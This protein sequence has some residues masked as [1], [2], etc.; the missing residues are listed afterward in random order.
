MRSWIVLTLMVALIFTA[1]CSPRQNGSEN[2]SAAFTGDRD[3][4]AESAEYRLAKIGARLDSLRAE[5]DSTSAATKSELQQEAARL[6]TE[7]QEAAVKLHD[8]R[9]SAGARW[10]DLRLELADLLDDLDRSFDRAR[11]KLREDHR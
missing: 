7:R 9:T 3:E 8:L 10:N 11:A 5:I 1:S 2:G 6:E 4:Y